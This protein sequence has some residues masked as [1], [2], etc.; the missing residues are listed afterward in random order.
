MTSE[1]RTTVSLNFDVS[2]SRRRLYRSLAEESANT[3][4]F[5]NQSSLVNTSE[6]SCGVENRIRP[7]V[8]NCTRLISSV[9]EDK[10][11]RLRAVRYDAGEVD[12][13]ALVDVDVGRALD[14]HVGHCKGKK[15]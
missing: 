4:P 9:P 2:L 13:A 6:H 15:D 11:R 1:K 14:A 7:R 10:R 3:R 12:G 8:T 5:W